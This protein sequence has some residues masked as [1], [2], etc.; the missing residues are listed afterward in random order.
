MLQPSNRREL[1]MRRTNLGQHVHS[2]LTVVAVTVLISASFVPAQPEFYFVGSGRVIVNTSPD[3]LDIRFA[4]PSGQAISWSTDVPIPGGLFHT[5]GQA[6][7]CDFSMDL[8]CTHLSADSVNV[9]RVRGSVGVAVYVR[10][11]NTAGSLYPYKLY[12]IEDQASALTEAD[13]TCDSNSFAQFLCA[14][15]SPAPCQ[16]TVCQQESGPN[17]AN[18]VVVSGVS[19][20]F[21]EYPSVPYSPLFRVIQPIS[22]SMDFRINRSSRA[23]ISSHLHRTVEGSHSTVEMD[24]DTLFHYY[25]GQDTSLSATLAFSPCGPEPEVQDV[26]VFLLDSS[27]QYVPSAMQASDGRHYR[28]VIPSA[29]ATS[30]S[31]T[32]Y[33]VATIHSGDLDMHCY[34]GGEIQPLR[35]YPFRESYHLVILVESQDVRLNWNRVPGNGVYYQIYSDSSSTGAFNNLVAMTTDSMYV[36][37]NAVGSPQFKKFYIV[38][39]YRP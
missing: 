38:R 39:A 31:L 15:C 18:L 27:G 8:D 25:V 16:D 13:L 6:T 32:Y 2:S 9:S 3:S 36:D 11:R 33:V 5:Q 17:Q 23:V 7:Q 24:L 37:S 4:L 10:S 29:F 19:V 21:P 28:G 34:G 1:T 26:S 30:D 20:F 12:G 35:A 14:A 22:S